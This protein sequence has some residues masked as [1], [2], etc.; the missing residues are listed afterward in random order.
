[1]V[2]AGGWWVTT[3]RYFMFLNVLLLPGRRVEGL[4]AAFSFHLSKSLM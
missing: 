2:E 3:A 1:M 4:A